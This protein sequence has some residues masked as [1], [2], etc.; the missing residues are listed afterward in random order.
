MVW[1]LIKIVLFVVAVV[2]ATMG[3]SWLLETSGEVQIAVAN[4]EFTVEP[5]TALLGLAA[6]L[7][8]FWLTLKVLVFVLGAFHFLNF[9]E[10]SI[11]WRYRKRA[12]ERKGFEA[13]A[14][15]ITALAAGE[16]KAAMAA[17]Q[18][19]ERLLKR[20]ELTNLIAA[21]AAEQSGDKRTATEVYKRL[22]EDNRTR[23]VGVRGLMKQKLEDGDT[24][25]A[26][27]LA[28]KAFALKPRHGETQDLLLELQA[29]AKNWGGARKTLDAKLRHGGLPRDVHKRRDAVLAL[30]QAKEIMADGKTVEAREAAIEAH[31]KSPDLI[32]AAVLAAHSYIEKKQPKYALRLLKKAWE[33]QPHPDLAAAFAA[34]APDETASERI[35]RFNTLTSI[36]PDHPESIMLL[37]ELHI[38]AEDFPGAR[39]A[40]GDLVETD[41]NARNLTIMAA[42][43][44]G[45]GSDD[46][47]VRGFLARALTA[48]RGPKWVC[49]KCQSVNGDWAPV[50]SN[51][52]G[53]DTLSWREP[54]KSDGA[55]D[56]G[57]EMLPLIVGAPAAPE[58][59]TSETVVDITPE[60]SRAS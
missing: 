35:T 22:L 17:A 46:A 15:G 47:I 6:L 21:Q 45:E 40:L 8:L 59:P 27:R 50:C 10:S 3:V 53:F 25:T 13:L 44:R 49:D 12:K 42:I 24:D 11:F 20:P 1:S 9:D 56:V 28:E 41:P 39:R 23:F 29:G 5:L 38:A 33:L 2:A 54:P 36:H 51:C 19:A 57:N 16:G 4:R 60:E 26:M 43:E 7:F 30:S 37:A 48:S 55:S 14:N 32:P 18:K 58:E 31:K 34:I 52:G